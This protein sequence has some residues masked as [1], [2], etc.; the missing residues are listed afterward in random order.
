P[1]T[2]RITGDLTLHGVTRSITIDLHVGGEADF[3][4]GT[5]RIGIFCE[6]KIN[7]S[8]FG[9][10]HMPDM[11]GDEVTLTVGFEAIRQ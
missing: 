8:D 9:M 10:T 3:P 7:R 2:G 4:K 6:F 5:R 1:K 11:V